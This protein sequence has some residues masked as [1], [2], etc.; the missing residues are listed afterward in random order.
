MQESFTEVYHAGGKFSNADE[1][2]GGA[3]AGE[4]YISGREKYA[5]ANEGDEDPT[6]HHPDRP[7]G[8]A[9]KASTC[10]GNDHINVSPWSHVQ[11]IHVEG[12]Q[13]WMLRTSG[14]RRY[15]GRKVEQLLIRGRGTHKGRRGRGR[16]VFRYHPDRERR[17]TPRRGSLMEIF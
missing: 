7:E 5:N 16:V 12:N 3:Y 14:D 8:A 15:R 9:L 10:L 11:Y 1:Y 17:G 6:F 2:K 13:T 4:K